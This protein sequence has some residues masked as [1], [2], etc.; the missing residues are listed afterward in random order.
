[1]AYHRYNVFGYPN[2]IFDSFHKLPVFRRGVAATDPSI[3]Y[4]GEKCFL[5]DAPCFPGSSGSPVFS[6]ENGTFSTDEEGYL[7]R[8][9]GFIFMGILSAGYQ[10]SINGRTNRA[11]IVQS[12]MPNNLGI[13]IKASCLDDFKPLLL[14]NGN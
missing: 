12:D 5:I 7:T 13:V 3:D 4:E 11:E 1:M 14:G 2:G 10:N 8:Y 9:S 6:Y